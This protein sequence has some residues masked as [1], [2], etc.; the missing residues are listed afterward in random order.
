MNDY[1]KQKMKSN[2]IG[3]MSEALVYSFL[4]LEAIGVSLIFGSNHMSSNLQTIIIVIMITGITCMIAGLVLNEWSAKIWNSMPIEERVRG[5]SPVVDN[6]A[7][8][9]KK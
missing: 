7:N 5:L 3:G 6:L 8:G 4:L 1:T 2:K 9:E